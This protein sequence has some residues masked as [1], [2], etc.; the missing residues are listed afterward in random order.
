MSDIPRVNS[1][2]KRKKSEGHQVMQNLEAS[3]LASFKT[4]EDSENISGAAKKGG[5]S[6]DNGSPP[7]KKKKRTHKPRKVIKGQPRETPCPVGQAVELGQQLQ[8][9]ALHIVDSQSADER[10][11]QVEWLQR[12]KAAKASLTADQEMPSVAPNQGSQSASEELDPASS[13][14]M[15]PHYMAPPHGMFVP[16]SFAAPQ[17]PPAVQSP[18]VLQSIPAGG[19]AH[20]LIGRLESTLNRVA[21]GFEANNRLIR[22]IL[23]QGDQNTNTPVDFNS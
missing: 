5:N 19:F 14:N 23:A 2:Y 20:Y 17:Y 18:Q 16:G 12:A 13:S 3:S 4:T 8:N 15:P 10:A 7:T 9:F 1:G 21:A 22:Q 11:T 6:S